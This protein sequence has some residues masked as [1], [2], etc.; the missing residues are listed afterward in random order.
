MAMTSHNLLPNASFELDF[1]DNVPTNWADTHHELTIRLQAT[2]RAPKVIPRSEAVGDAVDGERA[3]RVETEGND[4]GAAGHLTS[5]LVPVQ[6]CTPHTI[7]VY[8]RSE[9]PSAKLEIG[10]WTRPVDFTQTADSLSFPMPLSADWQRYSFVCSTDELEDRAVVDLRVTS[11]Q[12]GTVVWLDAVQLEMGPQATDFQPRREVEAAIAGH[13]EPPLI[14]S[15]SAATIRGFRWTTCRVRSRMKAR[16]CCGSAWD[17]YPG[18]L[19]T[20][21]ESPSPSRMMAAGVGSI[22]GPRLSCWKR[23]TAGP[24]NCPTGAWCSYTPTAAPLIAAGNV[25]R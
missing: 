8:A 19:P 25:P 16:G 12:A 4:G 10:L 24:C 9:D 1:G 15:L 22:S 11:D 3:A 18:S 2:D 13:R 7:S 17:L 23:C 14:H 20:R 6:P 21:S 5:P